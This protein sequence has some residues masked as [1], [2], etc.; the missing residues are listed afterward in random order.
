MII[1]HLVVSRFI[2]DCVKKVNQK[3]YSIFGLQFY[4]ECWSGARVGCT[5]QKFGQTN[6]CV[7]QN[8]ATC[9]DDSTMLCSGNNAKH[10][11][12]YVPADNPDA[13]LCPTT[14]KATFKTTLKIITKPKTTPKEITTPRT[15][16]KITTPA[17]RIT[18]PTDKITTPTDKTTTAKSTQIPTGPAKI[19]CGNIEYKL[20]KLGCWKEFG[21]VRPPRILPEL[22]LTAKDKS[23]SV[24]A[25]YEFYTQKYEDFIKR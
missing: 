12:V 16:P 22:L 7:N 1:F 17:R 18:T 8:M 9:S 19:K 3:G 23:S 15:T 6:G 21:H 20:T 10:T 25:G 13:A 24:Y 11:Y 5:Y 2:C 4:G 14:P